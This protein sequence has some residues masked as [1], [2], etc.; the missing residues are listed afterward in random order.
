MLDLVLKINELVL[1]IK[2]DSS[3][4]DRLLGV[5]VLLSFYDDGSDLE[6]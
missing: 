1:V 5:L 2:D 6:E 4:M 3:N